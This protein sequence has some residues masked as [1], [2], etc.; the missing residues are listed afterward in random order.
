MIVLDYTL[1]FFIFNFSIILKLNVLIISRRTANINS[2][3]III[4]II[5]IRIKFLRPIN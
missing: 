1:E 5:L 3:F 2:N 4:N